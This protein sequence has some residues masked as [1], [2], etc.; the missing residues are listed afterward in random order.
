MTV[1]IRERILR[2]IKL[3][4]VNVQK[5]VD[6]HVITWNTIEREAIDDTE[7]ELGDAV[8]ITEGTESNTDEL[9]TVRKTL[10]VFTEFWVRTQLGD[11]KSELANSV[12]TDVI[13]TLRGNP[14]LIEDGTVDCQLAIDTVEVRNELDLETEDLI[15]GVVVWNVVYRH[16]QDDPRKRG[17][18]VP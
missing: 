13:R 4:F 9:Q 8:G 12:L 1:S 14:R 2:Q 18:Q 11:D 15:G 10:E 7:Q 6:E 5:G 16:D 17:G 3:E